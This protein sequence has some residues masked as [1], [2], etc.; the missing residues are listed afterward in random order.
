MLL[1]VP[2][3]CVTHTPQFP[4]SQLADCKV[5]NNVPRWV[6]QLWSVEFLQLLSHDSEEIAVFSQAKVQSNCSSS[7]H[8]GREQTIMNSTH[9]TKCM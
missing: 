6:S 8:L 2:N 5:P 4:P 3:T 1:P 7:C 9:Y